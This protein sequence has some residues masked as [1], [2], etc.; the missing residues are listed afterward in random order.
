MNQEI[1]ELLD[2]KPPSVCKVTVNS[3]IVFSEFRLQKDWILSENYWGGF[4]VSKLEI[5]MKTCPNRVK[6]NVT[7]NRL[8]DLLC[9]CI[10]IEMGKVM[11][12]LVVFMAILSCDVSLNHLNCSRLTSAT[13]FK[14]ITFFITYCWL[15]LPS[16]TGIMRE[17][18]KLK[19]FMGC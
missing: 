10:C 2:Q 15:F 11:F 19:D 6:C 17:R 1:F 8:S 12:Q 13:H 18:K 7:I 9:K 14:K 3:S 5:L 16:F 4:E